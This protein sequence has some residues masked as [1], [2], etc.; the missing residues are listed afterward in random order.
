[1]IDF[2]FYNPTKIIFGS[3][4]IVNLANEIPSDKR[5]LI[6]YGHGSIKKN[7]IY[8]QVKLALKDRE[9]FEFGGIDPNPK[10]EQLL[11]AL[12]IIKQNGINFLLAVGGGSVIDG[13]KFIAAAADFKEDPWEL[14]KFDPSEPMKMATI[15]TALP[16]GC[17]LTLPATGSEMNCGAVISRASDKFSFG[18]T[19]LYPQ[20]SILDPTTTF[21][22][23][24]KQAANG[25][26]DT[27]V[28][29][30]EQYLTYP[31]NAAVQDRFAEGILLTLIEEA[32]K[33]FAD[34]QDYDARANL[35]WSAT[36]ALSRFSGTQT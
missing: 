23:P 14:L 6:T 5:I 19:L 13:T 15:N 10:Y 21:S 3:N 1:M 16:I 11:E 30:T 20:F 28:H 8:N 27:F 22:L 9:V 31:V 25:I 17:I 24:P 7:G 12:P 35:M 29:V 34:S 36:C 4:Q 26:I 32:P 33:I 18:H 2:T